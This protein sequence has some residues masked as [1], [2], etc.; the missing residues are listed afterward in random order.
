MTVLISDV[1]FFSAVSVLA[2]LCFA[3]AHLSIEAQTDTN[4]SASAG[5]GDH[6]QKKVSIATA[7]ALTPFSKFANLSGATSDEFRVQQELMRVTTTSGMS[8]EEILLLGMNFHYN[9]IPL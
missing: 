7:R 5:D 9:H 8:G 1:V 3:H 4:A 6:R 2:L